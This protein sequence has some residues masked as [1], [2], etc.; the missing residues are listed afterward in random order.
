M[1][2]IRVVKYTVSTKRQQNANRFYVCFSAIPFFVVI[3]VCLIGICIVYCRPLWKMCLCGHRC[4]FGNSAR[5]SQP[6][7][8]FF[9]FIFVLF[10]S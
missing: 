1:L 10:I 9:L 2:Y 6:I 7:F 4:P 3:G 8:F 5:G